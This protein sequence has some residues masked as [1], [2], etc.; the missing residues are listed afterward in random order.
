[1]YCKISALYGR[2]AKQPAP[3]AI[4]FYE[5]GIDVVFDCFG[6]DRVVFGSDWPVGRTT[7]DYAS[8]VQITSEYVDRLGA[9]VSEKLFVKNAAKF[10]GIEQH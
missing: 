8:L 1:M 6:E 7:G 3:Q 5:P 10:Y 9:G 4:E 2:S